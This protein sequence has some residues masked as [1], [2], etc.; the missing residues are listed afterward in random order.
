MEKNLLKM[1][2][3]HRTLIFLIMCLC[4]HVFNAFIF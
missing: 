2:S 1:L 3:E 4:I